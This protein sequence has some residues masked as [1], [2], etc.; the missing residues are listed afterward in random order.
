MNDVTPTFLD[1]ATDVEVLGRFF[2]DPNPVIAVLARRLA[3]RMPD[4]E[5]LAEAQDLIEKINNDLDDMRNAWRQAALQVS[6]IDE[7]KND[8][9][10]ISNALML[11]EKSL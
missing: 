7:L 9:E 6:K 8:I 4:T 3:N 5:K 10:H 2:H 1:T 11:L